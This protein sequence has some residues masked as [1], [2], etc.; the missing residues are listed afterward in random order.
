M[1]FGAAVEPVRPVPAHHPRALV[2][3][4]PASSPGCPEAVADLL[5]GSSWNFDV[6][7]VGP[8]EA[9][10]LGEEVLSHAML[11][12]QPG[13]GELRSAYRRL[14]RQAPAVRAFVRAGGRYL[15]FCLGGYLAGHSPGFDLLPG[16][17]DRYISSRGAGV[18]DAE[19]TVIT[20]RWR[21]E[22]RHV[23]F[24]DGPF[25][26]LDPTRGRADVLAVYDNGLPAALITPY[27][28]GAV[29]VV[30]PHPEAAPHWFADAGLRRPARAA[31]L[32]RDLV[33]A[34]MSA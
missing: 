18:T 23:F 28:A 32:G 29:G 11:Y 1:T 5:R 3:R 12:V 14:R 8:H 34:L 6:A 4:G 27:G 15:G 22:T 19:D 16:D 33:D 2:Y 13:G 24:Q 25:F 10:D 21:G 31:D 20:V 30:G 7:Y 26:D 9:R 17:A